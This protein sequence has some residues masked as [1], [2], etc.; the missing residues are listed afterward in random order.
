MIT[1]ADIVRIL[2]AQP[3]MKASAIAKHLEVERREV[4]GILYR[5]LH[6]FTKNDDDTWRSAPGTRPHELDRRPG[7]FGPARDLIPKDQQLEI[8]SAN[9]PCFVALDRMISLNYSTVPVRDGSGHIVGVF[10]FASFADRINGVSD[11]NV[12]VNSICAQSVE[13][14]MSTAKFLDPD[15][16]IDTTVDWSNVD[17][18]IIGTREEPLGI[19]TVS[20]VWAILNDFA[21]AYVLLNEIETDLRRLITLVAGEKLAEWISTLKVAPHAAKPES[22][23][24]FTFS[25]YFLL[26]GEKKVRWPCFEPILGQPRDL[27]TTEFKRVNT[28]RNELMH[29]KGQVG[30]AQ[31]NQLR[32]FRDRTR[33]A[34]ERI[35]SQ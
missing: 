2:K 7:P 15:L 12:P 19:L 16:Y 18:V 4:N 1:V 26:M 10:S 21:E 24:E 8:I 23:E 9:T 31:C 29:F 20:D 22:L 3:G 30:V 35:N 34:I 32:A 5:N 14:C 17:Y 11:S 13:D 6:L 28:L 27:F 25:Q 33:K